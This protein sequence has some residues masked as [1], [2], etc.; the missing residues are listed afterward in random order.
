MKKLISLFKKNASPPPR[1]PLSR[2]KLGE[3]SFL[4]SEDTFYGTSSGKYHKKRRNYKK[5][6]KAEYRKKMARSSYNKSRS[7]FREDLMYPSHDVSAPLNTDVSEL[8]ENSAADFV[9]EGSYS[10][11]G[12]S[13]GSMAM[14]NNKRKKAIII[15]F[16]CI[17]FAFLLRLTFS[18]GGLLDYRSKVNIY[19]QKLEQLEKMKEE[20]LGLTHEIA[21]MKRDK[22]FQMKL[23]REHLGFVAKDEYVILF[24]KD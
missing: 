8:K 9:Q 7:H 15:F 6:K 16:W 19:N 4:E 14:N 20:N 5:Y 12:S 2:S 13:F 10:Q 22:D 1:L 24:S 3:K 23:V 17:C 11:M 18:Q 21:R